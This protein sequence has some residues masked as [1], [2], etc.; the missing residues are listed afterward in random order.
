[1]DNG[2]QQERL[3]ALQRYGILNTQ[4]EESYNRYTHLAAH[5]FDV[6][7]ALIS[8]VDKDRIWI[9]AGHGIDRSF[10]MSWDPA[11]CANVISSGKLQVVEDT[12][13]NAATAGHSMV[14][15]EFGL[16]FYAGIPLLSKEG[17]GLGSFCLIDKKPRKFSARHSEQFSFLVSL[18]MDYMELDFQQRTTVVKQQET[19]KAL[20]HD[21]KNPL[22]I[23]TLQS[24]LLMDEN[25][26]TDDIIEMSQQI[27]T[28]GRKINDL[29]NKRLFS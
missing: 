7:V 5:L 4:E 24:E 17:Y 25:G 6:P 20:A 28:A 21:L 27:S 3:E 18:L 14:K 19:I 16:R 2:Q 23:V 10:Q 9:K 15:S 13:K 12:L 22:T 26:A 11:L 8:M 1:M 29:I